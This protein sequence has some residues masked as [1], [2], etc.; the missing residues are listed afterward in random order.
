MAYNRHTWVTGEIITADKL[1]NIEEG[2]SSEVISGT[3]KQVAGFDEEGNLKPIVLGVEQF[4]DVNGF[5]EFANGVLT[6]TSMNA[7]TKT[8]FMFF[9]EF[10]PEVPKAGTFPLYSSRGTLVTERAT[11]PEDAINLGQINGFLSSTMNGQNFETIQE[12][13]NHIG[14]RLSALENTI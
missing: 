13:V 8:A 1:N 7:E 9:V 4:S 5:P 6:A 14:D 12:L 11:E 10:S 3:I 2:I